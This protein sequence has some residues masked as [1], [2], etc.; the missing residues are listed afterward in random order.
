MSKILVDTNVLIYAIDKDSRFYLR[1]R[2]LLFESNFELFTTSKNLI[3]FLTVVTRGK[4]IP[5]PIEKAMSVVKDFSRA[6]TILYPTKGSFAIFE[7]LLEKY[8][9]T[10]LKI[11]D[12]EIISIGLVN[13]INQ[14]AT[15][16]S[17]D[18]E[19]IEEICIDKFIY[20]FID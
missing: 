9:P 18:F 15:F 2:Q 7:E 6:F 14:I 4:E 13:G 3:E 19:D 16:N 1:S 17:K 11:H 20:L 10:G 12:Y 8:R 5:L